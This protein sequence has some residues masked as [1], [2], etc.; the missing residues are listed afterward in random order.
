M[1]YNPPQ[2]GARIRA[3]RTNLGYSQETFSERLSISR[4]HLA[5]IETG[6]RNPSIDLFIEIAEATDV[7]LDYLVLGQSKN[8]NLRTEIHSVISELIRIESLL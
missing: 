4:E 2:I 6:S 3:I 1:K 8:D 5:R 7:S